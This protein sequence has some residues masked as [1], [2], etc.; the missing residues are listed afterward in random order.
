[1]TEDDLIS[2]ATN[3]QLLHRLKYCRTKAKD[4]IAALKELVAV[5]DRIKS[6][7][8]MRMVDLEIELGLA[9]SHRLMSEDPYFDAL[10]DLH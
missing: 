9:E 6:E 10:L 7:L 3:A 2:H 5:N 8:K 1:M 4:H